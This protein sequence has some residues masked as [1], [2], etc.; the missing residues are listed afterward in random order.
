[1][2]AVFRSRYLLDLLAQVPGPAEEARPSA[3][4]G[5]AARRRGRGG[6]RGLRSFAAIGQRAAGAGPVALT[7]LG[8][9]RGP[10]DGSTFRRAFALV[11][12]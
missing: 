10:A 7:A 12:G 11:S 1:M 8:A 6:D 9:A 3:C 4:A 2:M 5:R